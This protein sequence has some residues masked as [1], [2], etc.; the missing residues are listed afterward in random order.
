MPDPNNK[1]PEN[2]PGPYY[3]DDTCI[4][5]DLCRSAAPQFFTRHDPS[6]LSYVYRQPETPE[7]IA[8]AE[9]A[10]H[11]CPADS[12]GHDGADKTPHADLAPAGASGSPS[13]P[14]AQG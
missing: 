14:P 10:R 11:D 2:I 3:V 13:K 6:G 8:Q 1:V 9:E 12:I 5:C 4:D 7:E